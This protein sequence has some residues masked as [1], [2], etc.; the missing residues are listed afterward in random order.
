VAQRVGRGIALLF[1]VLGTRRGSGR[2][3]APAALYGFCCRQSNYARN[4]LIITF[5]L[6]NVCKFF[7]NKIQKK[8]PSVF[9]K[10]TTDLKSA[11]I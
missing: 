11:S 9:I 5:S 10:I 4:C 2:Q 6:T 7:A 3:H 1:L 8:Q